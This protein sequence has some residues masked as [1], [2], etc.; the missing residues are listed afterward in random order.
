MKKKIKIIDELLNRSD[1]F[2]DDFN[3][4]KVNLFSLCSCYLSQQEDIGLVAVGLCPSTQGI[5]TCMPLAEATPVCIRASD[6]TSRLGDRQA[7]KEAQKCL[8]VKLNEG[9]NGYRRTLDL[10]LHQNN[11]R[12]V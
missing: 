2:Y 9:R 11:P 6:E 1:T 4:F 10:K 3:N 8:S 7:A 5:F 12:D